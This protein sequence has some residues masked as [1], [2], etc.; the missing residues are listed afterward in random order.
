VPAGKKLPV[1]AALHDHSGFKYYGKEKITALPEEQD[2]LRELKIKTYEGHSWATRLAKRG[3]AVLAH[4]L[5]L[6]G[7]R[8]MIAEECT[9]RFTANMTGKEKGSREYI[10]AYHAFCK[11]HENLIA[12]SLFM[13]GTTWPGIMLYEDMRAIDYLLTRKDVDPDRIGCGGLSGGGERTIF[14][15]GMDSRIKC[16]VC[17]CFMTTFAQT[18]KHNIP[19][20]TWMY[21]LPH[22]SNLIDLPDLLSLSG[23]V[24][25]MVQFREQDRLFSPEGMRKSN[26]KLIRIYR[27]MEKEELYSGRFFAGGHQFDTAMQDEAFGWFDRWLKNQA[28]QSS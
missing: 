28:I 22:L 21:H 4:D 9:P 26:E 18:V 12:K 16:S 24:P 6:W 3:Y 10:E 19:N 25:Q 20:H 15:T 11:E 8:K 2:I 23:G 5:F 1:V 17:V 14:L 13:A 27:K 7:S